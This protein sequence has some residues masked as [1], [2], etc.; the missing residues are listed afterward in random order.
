MEVID[1]L[2]RVYDPGRLRLAWKRVKTNAGAAGIDKMTTGVFEERSE[3]YLSIIHEKLKIGKYRFKPARRVLIPKPG[4][5]KERKLGIPVVFDRIVS[6]SMNLVLDDL[7]DSDFTDSNFG[8]R[9]TKSQRQAIYHLRDHVVSGREWAVSI[10]L[11][12]FFDE[13]PHGLILKLIRRKVK[14]EGFVTLLCRALQCGVYTEGGF[15]ETL[16]GSPQGSPASP[17]ISN[18]VLNELDQ[19]MEKRGLKYCRWADDFVVL[20]KSEKAANRVMANLTRFLECKLGLPVNKEKSKVSRIEDTEFL[21]FRILRGKIQISTKSERKFKDKVKMLTKRNNPYSMYENTQNLNQFLV[22]WV[23]YFKIQEFKSHLAKLDWFV[24][25]RLRSMQLRK[26][27]TPKKFQ[28]MLARAGYPYRDPKRCWVKM[29]RWNSIHRREVK[30]ALGLRWYRQ[31]G[32]IFLDDY[33]NLNP[34]LKFN[35]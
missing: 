2:K 15:E 9:K 7:F 10:D 1:V 34:E 20:L 22:G 28:R 17:I 16:K 8:F 12:G 18:I 32:L 27:K 24:R 35:H 13:I 25:N 6:Q 29:N 14:D 19:E 30:F 31:S 26:W 11:Q 4:S 3:E 33:R 5:T 23:G 21:G